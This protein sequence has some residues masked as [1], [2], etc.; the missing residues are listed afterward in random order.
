MEPP[1]IPSTERKKRARAYCFTWNNPTDDA[2]TRM[3]GLSACCRY[4]C[5]Q[6]EHGSENGTPHVQAYVYFENL[7]SP[8]QCRERLY[9]YLAA[10]PHIE[11]SRG[12]PQQNRDYC[13]KPET[14]IVGTFRE[15]GELPT[16]GNRTDLEQL[17]MQL[18]TREVTC[19]D[20]ATHNPGLFVKFSKGLQAL[21]SITAKGRDGTITPVVHWWF[22]STGTGKTR[23]AFENYPKAYW[24]MGGKKDGEWWDGYNSEET[25]IVDDYRCD[26]C[27]FHY[28][29]KMIDRYPM[30]V[31]V[32]GSTT[33]LNATIFVFTCPDRPE[34]M[35]RHQTTEKLNQLL[36]RI[37]SIVE[38]GS[39]SSKTIWKDDQTVYEPVSITEPIFYT[40]N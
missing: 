33:M 37:S 1:E 19:I 29:L 17:A 6:R 23:A 28:L 38:Y 11:W 27:P 2:E 4:L 12:T 36:R 20:I 39:N 18:V 16:I 35:W 32:K 25:V 8:K 22:G 7:A 15:F 10:K 21:Q 13:S 26:M 31:G 14:G 34:I 3:E 40:H 30:R 24:K 5:Y 9:H